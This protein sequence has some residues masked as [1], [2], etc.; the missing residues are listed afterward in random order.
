VFGGTDEKGRAGVIKR[1]IRRRFES[2]DLTIPEIQ[3]KFKEYNMDLLR[4]LNADIKIR[5]IKSMQE[6]IAYWKGRLVEAK[7]SEIYAGKKILEL[8]GSLKELEE[9]DEDLIDK[10]T[11]RPAK[12][13]RLDV[14]ESSKSETL[15]E[16]E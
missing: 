5:K 13:A 11:I 14:N 4:D 10:E 9:S 2:G 6:N 15:A 8:E 3:V 7:A 1:K 12:R 16:S